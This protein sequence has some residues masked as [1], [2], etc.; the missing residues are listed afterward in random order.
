VT[1]DETESLE[2]EGRFGSDY[3][4]RNG[5]RSPSV[6]AEWHAPIWAARGLS[7]EIVRGENERRARASYRRRHATKRA[8]NRQI[9]EGVASMRMGVTRGD[10]AGGRRR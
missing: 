3:S 7:G 8:G 5:R 4:C 2:P 10:F 9:E 1:I 6:S